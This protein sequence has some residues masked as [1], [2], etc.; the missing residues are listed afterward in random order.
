MPGVPTESGRRSNPIN[1]TY[2]Y[3]HK[4]KQDIVSPNLLFLG[5]CFGL[6]VSIDGGS[7][8]A[9]YTANVPGEVEIRDIVIQPEYDDLILAS[10]GRGIIIIDDI[11][12]L[13]ELTPDLLNKDVVILPSKPGY[14]DPPSF[15]G[16]FSNQAGNYSAPNMPTDAVICYYLK[17]RAVIGDFKIEILNAAG[18]LVAQLPG[19]KRKGINRITWNMRMKPP[20]VAP[21]V[22]ATF[23]GNIGPMLPEG[24]YT[25][26]LTKGS[27]LEAG[28]GV[29]SVVYMGTIEL[30]SN[31]N[32]IH[33]PE[34]RGLQR[35][36][37]LELYAMMEDLAFLAA[38]VR[39]TMEQA[40]RMNLTDATAKLDSLQ[41]TLAV[42]K[43]TAGIS[44][45]EQLRERIADLYGDVVFYYGKPTQSQ[46]DRLDVLK[47][48]LQSAQSIFAEI[49]Q[50]LPDIKTISR[51]EWDK[52]NR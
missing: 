1:Q 34:D 46:L 52:Q 4:I 15:G 22:R 37:A 18:E 14:V 33:S 50:S 23:A 6:Y 42:S 45:E 36:T 24:L 7:S 30:K 11:S 49:I 9:K 2:G 5:T 25:I 26:R 10:H 43:E 38:N 35:K 13:R 47:L 16:G 41:K 3:A 39:S 31:P 12:P 51:D 29:S 17:E 20:R 32:S 28:K 8:W 21:G 19:T 48:E 27:P 40:K 44:G